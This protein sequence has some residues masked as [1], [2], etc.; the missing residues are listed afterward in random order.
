MTVSKPDSDPTLRD[1]AVAP[2]E[3]VPGFWGQRHSF[4]LVLP[5]DVEAVEITATASDPRASVHVND[6]PIISGR[7]TP[8]VLVDVGRT[9]LAVQVTAADGQ[10]RKAYEIKVHRA[11][12]RPDWKCLLE[13]APFKERDSEGEIVFDGRMWVIGGYTPD[14]VNDVWSTPNGLDWTHTGDI[15]A[16][17]GVNIPVCL[18]HAGRIWVTGQDGRLYV[19]S[20]GAQWVSVGQP[21]W[22][23]RHAPGFAIFRGRMWVIGGSEG[24]RM[25]N[26]VWSSADGE[27]WKKELAEAPWSPRQIYSNL[28]VH[29][30]RLWLIGGGVQAYQ[31]FKSYRDV[32]ST[33]DGVSW[34]RAT[35][36]A[37]WPGRIW[38]SCVTY[39]NRMWLLGGFR[40]QPT[41]NNFDDVWYSADGAN[42][43]HLE[44]DHI[45]EPRHEI[46]ALVF[47]DSLWVIAGNAWPL[48]NDVWR[49]RIDGLTF[50]TRP[51]L[52]EFIGTEYRYEA[53]A[54]F[55][56]DGGALRYR[57]LEAPDWL[58]IDEGSGC[59]RGRA[60][61]S[62]DYPVEIEVVAAAGESA[63]QRYVLHVLPV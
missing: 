39:R 47:D 11:T 42:W 34:E 28:V 52:E 32:W 43:S 17:G 41:W 36:A 27:I 63:R 56:A 24:A 37:P 51:V 10:S 5:H 49:L 29:N 30:D 6:K 60:P 59:V 31:P 19:S 20:D 53:Q 15:P 55:H 18:A 40:A 9:V 3:M 33:A 12:P 8:P 50:L 2:G 1:L 44:T 7:P 22:S 21:P 13:H 26:D 4:A 35:D 57:L 62:G 25:L 61:E 14:V 16:K 54:D 58:T 48:K 38:T 45:W 46:S 23:P